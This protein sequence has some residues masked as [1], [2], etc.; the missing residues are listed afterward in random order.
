M[1]LNIVHCLSTYTE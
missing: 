1:F